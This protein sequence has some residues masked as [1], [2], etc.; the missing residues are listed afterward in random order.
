[1][2]EKK[3]ARKDIE[4][5]SYYDFMGYLGASFFN[6]GGLKVTDKLLEL[7]GVDKDTRVL[8]VGCGMGFSSC[9]IAEKYGCK[10]V[11]IEIA[12]MMIQKARKR[13][14]KMGLEDQVEFRV[15]DAYNLPFEDNS[16]DTVVTQFV[17]VFLEKERAFKEFA[18]VVKNRGVVGVLEPYKSDNIPA[19]EADRIKDAENMISEITELPF[20]M[21]TPSEWKGWFEDAHLHVMETVKEDTMMGVRE[22]IKIFGGVTKLLSTLLKVIYYY[23]VSKPLRHRMKLLNRAKKIMF[24]NKS[25]KKHIGLIICT[26]RKIAKP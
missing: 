7:T 4:N 8:D 5:L 9:Y 20:T 12:E 3:L 21:P 17:S 16:F 25:T 19:E 6:W 11:G 10:V 26:G 18:R 13:A 1:M 15:G 23:A 14:K 2:Q 24:R 22:A